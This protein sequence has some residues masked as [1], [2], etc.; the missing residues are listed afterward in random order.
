MMS[1][2]AIT[3]LKTVNTDVF[4]NALSNGIFTSN[5]RYRYTAVDDGAN[6]STNA[7]VLCTRLAM[8]LNGAKA[9][10]SS[11]TCLGDHT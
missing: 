7:S 9:V 3:Q 2:L 1:S 5:L 11:A 6:K 10:R 4:N 8:H